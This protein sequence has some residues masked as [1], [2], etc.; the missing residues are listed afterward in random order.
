M[1]ILNLFPPRVPIGK[2]ADGK[3]VYVS[4]EFS[5]ALQVLSDRV[6]GPL[7]DNGVD[8]FGD[9]TGAGSQ[10]TSV[11]DIVTQPETLDALHDTVSQSASAEYQALADV[12]QSAACEVLM[13]DVVQPSSIGY[14]GIIT[15][16]SLVGKTIIIQ[17][18]II[19]GFQ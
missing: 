14:N 1:A 9:L 4:P 17:N 7:G 3:S 5:R 8:T 13:P 10:D 2:T 18:G 16:A 19:T 6:G 12:L 11:T 15:S